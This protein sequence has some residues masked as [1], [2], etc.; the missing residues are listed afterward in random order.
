MIKEQHRMIKEQQQ[1]ISEQHQMI[2]EQQQ[3]MKELEK[4]NL[5]YYELMKQEM[6]AMRKENHHK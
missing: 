5:S 4:K 1:K 2:S 6:E 3:M